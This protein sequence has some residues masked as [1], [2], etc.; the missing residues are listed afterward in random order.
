MIFRFVY[1]CIVGFSFS[2]E[3]YQQI[4]VDNVS[5]DD[6]SLFQYSGIEFDHADYRRGEYIEFAIS[7]RDLSTLNNRKMRDARSFFSEGL[8]TCFHICEI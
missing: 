2:N 5:D 6:I 4:K 1:V 3:I 8:I 7:N